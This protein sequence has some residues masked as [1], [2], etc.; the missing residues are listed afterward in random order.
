MLNNVKHKIS[1]GQLILV[2]CVLILFIFTFLPFYLMV[3]SSIKYQMQIIDQPWWFSLPFHFSNYVKAFDAL[4]RPIINS[5]IVTIIGL[6]ITETAASMAAYSFTRYDFPFKN[7]IFFSILMLLMIP[8]FVILIPQFIQMTNMG[9]FNTY[10]GLAI[11]PGVHM[12]P[13][14]FIL[15]RSFFIGIPG[16]LFENAQIEGANNWMIF[17]KIVVPLSKPVLSTVAILAGF[18]I[19]NNYVWS[20]VISQGDKVQP[21]IVAIAKLKG[22]I[23]EGDGLKLAGYV[24]ASLPLVI[25]FFFM[26][27]PFISGITAG[28][29]KG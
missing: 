1:F 10:L 3:V 9:F 6:V 15:M 17:T 14:A 2:G 28:A 25:L 26:T 18:T 21:V 24:I 11:P 20:L 16:S 27:K 4:W 29:V 13:L 5:F 12:C 7:I 19:W 8:G 23:N 22:N